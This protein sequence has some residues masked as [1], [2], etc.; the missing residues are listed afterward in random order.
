MKKGSIYVLLAVLM[1]SAF[2]TA[3][4]AVFAAEDTD[5]MNYG[6]GSLV[7]DL[8][9]QMAWD[10]ASIDVIDQVCEGLFGYNLSDPN[11][12]II[13]VLAESLGTWNADATEY[14]VTLKEG[15]TFHDDT[16][17]D[18]NDVKFTFDRL[19]YLIENRMTQIAE[20]YEPL[21]SLYPGTPLLINEIEVIDEYTVR[22]H[23]NYPYVPFVALLCFSGSYILPDGGSIP[24]EELLD[25]ATDVLVGTGPYKYI[26]KTNEYT[27]LE[28]FADW[29]G[30]R[31]D[32]FMKNIIFLLYS[33]EI[34]KCQDFLSGDLDWV[35]RILPEFL[36]QFEASDQFVVSEPKR[37]IVILYL[38][39]NNKIINKTM[40]QAISYA[41]DYDFVIDNL[42]L[43][44]AARLTSPVPEGI[45]YHN[46]DLDYP[47]N[48][49][50]HARQILID[51]GIVN[52]TVYP[53]NDDFAW[54]T[55][56]IDNPIATYNYTWNDGNEFRQDL[57]RLCQDNLRKI[58]IQITFNPITWGEYLTL[59]FYEP[60]KLEL[61]MLGW[62]PDYNDPSNYIN[63]SFSPTSSSNFAQ[64]DDTTLNNLMNDGLTETDPDARRDI[65]YEIQRFIVEDLMPWIFL[66]VPLTQEIRPVYIDGIQSNPMGKIYF[67]SMF[68]TGI[69]MPQND[70]T[71]DDTT[72]DDTTTDDTT[73]D[74]TTT[75]DTTT[76]DTTTD[77]TTTDDTTTDDTTTDDTTTDGATTNDENPF[78][79]II[80]NIPGYVPNIL[81]LVTLV[82]VVALILKNRCRS[83]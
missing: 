30:E 76:D 83:S 60:W 9:P 63:P 46:P 37:G 15:I 51:A 12:A 66:Y 23:L 54:Y 62:G 14:T 43:G 44:N 22:F 71:T 20:L 33:D 27:K 39:M 5:T 34:V 42:A 73:T 8:D 52:G 18:A 28:Y 25:T 78:E 69:G 58:G 82:S 56:A 35:D 68:W 11:L 81:G 53:A 41:F 80:I 21:A 59:L 29:H 1:I 45:M 75:D 38:G 31:P 72:T 48:N 50:T 70:T 65:Y 4:A 61:Y 6:V 36:P 77:D 3:P 16:A 7:V 2:A 57:G 17:F 67:A 79:N 40:R 19:N 55:L 10:S 47:T 13:P 49:V 64:V 26:E 32:R 24:A 74:D